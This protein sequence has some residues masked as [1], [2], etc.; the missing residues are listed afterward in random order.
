M[1][2]ILLGLAVAALWGSA[3]TLA[4]KVTSRMGSTATTL[5]AQV[6][7]LVLAGLVALVVGSPTTLSLPAFME[8]MLSGILLGAIGALAYLTL[9]KALAYGPLAVA[10]PLVSAQGG[11]TLLAAIIVLHELPSS[12]QLVFLLLTF[13]GV[14]LA[15]VNGSEIRRLVFAHALHTLL[16]PGIVLALVSML[17]FGLLTFG[18]G[19]AAR[20]TDWLLC[21]VWTRLFSCLLLAI[22]L[23]LETPTAVKP[24]EERAGS[25]RQRW[26]DWLSGA[27]AGVVGCADV[28]GM[29]LLSLASTSG[30]IG[31]VGMVASAYGVIPLAAGILLFKERPAANQVLGV[32]VLIA[33]LLGVASASPALHWPLLAA[34]GVL[35]LVFVSGTLCRQLLSARRQAAL[36]AGWA[37]MARE[38]R[39]LAPAQQQDLLALLRET[40]MGLSTLTRI[41]PCVAIVGSASTPAHVPAYRAA[42]ETARLL[43]RA[44]FGILTTGGGGIMQAARQGADDAGMLAVTCLL[45]QR[46]RRTAGAEAEEAEEVGIP[47]CG[48]E[49]VVLRFSSASSRQ[50]T[51]WSAA[52]AFV[53][54]PGGLETLSVLYQTVRAQQA[55]ARLR[56]PIVLYEKS[57]WESL[58]DRLPDRPFEA[59]TG[60]TGPHTSGL[61][62]LCDQPAEIAAYVTAALVPARRSPQQEEGR[63]TAEVSM[64]PPRRQ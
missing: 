44:G 64:T 7:G 58:L 38:M 24:E 50:L 43:A 23:R 8:S 20:E 63:K 46:K 6:S 54:F 40:V 3:D 41:P 16:S 21:V 52:S 25:G 42:Y 51:V 26:Q 47:A 22:C 14:M 61:L 57:F 17:S 28:G 45:D 15:A 13:V 56:V 2:T 18:L 34:V 37:A 9:Y 60:A 55:G 29:L 31:V 36:P 59:G 4:A 30:S 53:L 5:I 1:E 10:S 11:V 62:R 27:G 35:L 12:W 39:M 32:L 48:G 49:V 19:L 33:G